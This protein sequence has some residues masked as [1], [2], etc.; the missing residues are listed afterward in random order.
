MAFAQL[1]EILPIADAA[2]ASVVRVATAQFRT[3]KDTDR[4]LEQMLHLIDEAAAGD[5]EL[6]HF[7]E[8]CNFP[9]SYDDREEAWREAITIPGP[10]FNAI[11][12]R[13]K[14]HGVHVSFNAAVRGE[15]PDAYMVNHLVGPDGEYIGGNKKQVLMFI[16]R[17]AF[18]PADEENRVFD[19]ALGR[20][21]LL[22][23]MD[24]LI[25]ETSRMLACQGADILL[26]SL[27]SNG[28]D[29]ANFHIPARSAENGVYMI[30]AN[31]IGDMVTGADLDRLRRQTGM[32]REFIAGAGESGITGPEGQ[33]IARATRDGF[34]LTFADLDLGLVQR[35]R[36]LAGR[37][38]ECYGLMVEDNLTLA[39]LALDRPEAGT[40]RIT[41]VVP[42]VSTF[43]VALD[44]AVAA[45][46]AAEP[47]LA[48]LP[49][50]FAWDP[51][52][53]RPTAIRQGEIDLAIARLVA[54]AA[55]KHTYIVAG[56][57]VVEGARLINRAILIGPDGVVGE[58]RQVHADPALGWG[59]GGSVFPVFDLPFGRVAM[60]LGEDLIYPEAARVLARQG[61]D[62][63]ACPA[64]WR[65][66]W[67]YTLMLPERS[68]ENHVTVA[69]AGR[70]DS[71]VPAPGTIITTSSVYRFPDTME[72]NNPDRHKANAPSGSFTVEIDLAP[73][74]DKRLMATTD[75]I[76][77]TQPQLY[78]RL[79]ASALQEQGA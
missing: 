70:A 18:R 7:Q 28:L 15:Y 55:N 43:A 8:C 66:D 58:Y 77:D 67:Q 68:A 78:G 75:L 50:L 65:T 10:M 37:R 47:G 49:E 38:P 36:R 24:G 14:A 45:I 35:D 33:V 62:L 1:N 26:N 6:V 72:V 53:L 39:A 23:C 52:A 51:E 30:S 54:V 11:S 25:P 32:S 4:V 46:E 27:C 5:A 79:V 12:A 56:V 29:E 9:T 13:A 34:G 57:P 41:T 40:V 16:E 63:I 48:V 69:A 71:P 59:P 76:M 42:D 73:N 74:R 64:T 17:E 2:K 44:K 3:G 22:S 21:G 19:T 61:V 20:I 31:R 60:L